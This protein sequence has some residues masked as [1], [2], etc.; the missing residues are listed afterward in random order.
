[1]RRSQSPVKAY[2][3]EIGSR[4]GKKSRRKLDA[5]QARR[6]V[7][8]REARKAFREHHCEIFWSA[9]ED[10]VIREEQV[11]YIIQNMKREG[12]RAIYEKARRIQKLWGTTACR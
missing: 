12:N 9:P 8:V 6:M 5:D 3:R 4:G 10:M 11:P 2:L 7:A 1:M